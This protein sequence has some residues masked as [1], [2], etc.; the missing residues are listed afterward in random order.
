M[1][2][3]DHDDKARLVEIIRNSTRFLW[4]ACQLKDFASY[5]RLGGIPSRSLLEQRKMPFTPFET[6]EQDRVNFVWD[7]VFCNLDDF[8]CWFAEGKGAV[9]NPYGPIQMRMCPE[10]VFDAEDVAVS[11]MS[12]GGLG[13]DREDESIEL[14]EFAKLLPRGSKRVDRDAKR[15]LLGPH[16]QTQSNPEVSCS[17]PDGLIAF[18]RLHGIVVDPIRIDGVRLVDRAKTLLVSSSLQRVLPQTVERG[19]PG[20]QRKALYQ[21]LADILSSGWTVSD[22]EIPYETLPAYASTQMRGWLSTIEA[23]RLEWLLSRYCMYTMS[24]TIDEAMASRL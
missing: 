18:E 20:Y 3:R 11:L 2:I 6:D 7:K 19:C 13:F 4:H 17:M 21:E 15:K 5:L 24:G 10:F 16:H 8:G 12:A 14:E 9:P 1:L 22:S 23:N